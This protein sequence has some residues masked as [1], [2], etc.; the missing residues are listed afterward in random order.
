V[1]AVELNDRDLQV[2]RAAIRQAQAHLPQHVCEHVTLSL[3]FLL[4]LGRE[5]LQL[6]S[7]GQLRP[8]RL[9]VKSSGW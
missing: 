1:G 5:V 4:L 8:L 7:R 2:A 9:F 3:R 6:Q